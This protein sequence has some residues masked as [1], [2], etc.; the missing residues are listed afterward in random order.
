MSTLSA[1]ERAGVANDLVA[2]LGGDWAVDE[3]GGDGVGLRHLPTGLPFVAVPGGQ[4]QMGITDEDLAAVATYGSVGAP[5]GLEQLIAYGRPV[6]TVRVLPFLFSRDLVALDGSGGAAVR[7][8]FDD[9][10]VYDRAEAQAGA[11]R[12]G[13]RLPSEAE[14]E[15]V[16]RDGGI[17]TF[18]Y[19]ALK[20][21]DAEQIAARHAESEEDEDYDVF[22]D[23]H[24]YRDA[25]S[26]FGVDGLFCRQWLADDWHPTF[27][28]APDTSEPWVG[29][30][31]QGVRRGDGESTGVVFNWEHVAHET[32]YYILA[33]LREPGNTAL[34]YCER[35]KRVGLRFAAPL[36]LG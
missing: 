32:F 4:F 10:A 3:G 9:A 31:P 23:Y 36:H 16:G 34:P 14:F 26:R 30:D 27:D 11:A 13:F 1:D 21:L 2:H 17:H 28:G 15:W 18:L 35:E 7:K 8:R 22:E 24:P 25:V 19:G 12:F 20:P 5:T 6:R 29:G 33:G